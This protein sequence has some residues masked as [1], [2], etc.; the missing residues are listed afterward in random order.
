MQSAN[1]M[2]KYDHDVGVGPGLTAGARRGGGA[3]GRA[4]HESIRCRA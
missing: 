3:G 4:V 1:R 2:R